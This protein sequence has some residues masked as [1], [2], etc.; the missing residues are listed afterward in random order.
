MYRRLRAV[1]ETMMAVMIVAV[2]GA[3]DRRRGL[4]AVLTL[5]HAQLLWRLCAE[6]TC[7]RARAIAARHL[8]RR[9]RRSLRL[10]NCVTRGRSTIVVP[11]SGR[12][13]I[14]DTVAEIAQEHRTRMP[15]SSFT[16]LET[17]RSGREKREEREAEEDEKN[18][19]LQITEYLLE[20]KRRRR[21]GNEST[22][23]SHALFSLAFLFREAAT[24]GN[25]PRD[26]S[27]SL[28]SAR[29]SLVLIRAASRCSPMLPAVPARW[30][31]SLLQ[32]SVLISVPPW[33]TVA[34][35]GVKRPKQDVDTSLTRPYRSTC[36][37]C[38]AL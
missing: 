30:R 15:T 21:D 33:C 24:C 2:A 17:R 5:C 20:E 26:A 36:Q 23:R 34:T 3:A 8:P 37:T 27:Q 10:Q 31:G 18:H 7:R 4:V 9:M 28:R 38:L 6:F 12:A 16:W 11:A 22:N 1:Q 35:L 25:R 14:P 13:D 19:A 32:R 29:A